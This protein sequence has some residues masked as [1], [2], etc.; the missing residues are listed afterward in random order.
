MSRGLYIAVDFKPRLGG[1][2]E[3]THQMAKHLTELGELITVVTPFLDGCAE[4]DSACGYPVIRVDTGL[5]APNWLKS[6]L[7]R[8][9]MLIWI[10]RIARRVN[11]DYLI[12][13]R[14]SPIAGANAILA[15]R[16][17]GIPFFLFAHGSEFSQPVPL[18]FSRKMAVRAATRVICV[19][20]YIRSLVLADG[21]LPDKVV[22]IPNG[23]DLREIEAYRKRTYE[24]RFPEVDAA[25]P[26]GSPTL[27]TVSR[28]ME[29]KGIHK[30]IEAM[31]MIIEHIPEARYVIVGDGSSMARF[32]SLASV[33]PARDS[34]KFLGARIDDEKFACYEGCDIFIMPSVD[35]SFPIVFPEANAFGKPVIGGRSGGVPDTISHEVNGLL[36]NP[37][38]TDDIAKAAIRLLMDTEEARGFGENGRKRVQNEFNW[39]QSA[40]KLIAVIN[41]ASQ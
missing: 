32:R 34:I 37:L 4:F 31:P 18:K 30:V 26:G 29:R 5:G 6:R 12:L 15:A 23:F 3:H 39:T 19:S 35:D 17:L 36:V 2:A 33:S 8:R 20:G 16:L 22:T 21:V 11:A 13:D 38:D 24:G 41:Q 10:L 14:W 28:M 7:D 40:R 1:I 9:L 27:L 25:F